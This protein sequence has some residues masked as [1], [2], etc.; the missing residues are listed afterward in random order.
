M[1]EN[2]PEIK[3]YNNLLPTPNY[4]TV[5]D[6]YYERSKL[7][8]SL[9]FEVDARVGDGAEVTSKS[10]VFQLAS[11]LTNELKCDEC[12]RDFIDEQSLKRHKDLVHEVKVAPRF[13][14]AKYLQ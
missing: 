12:K 10:K 9:G 2:L 5:M 4:K 8:R 6:N 7:F 14:L 11:L 1:Q 13:V 3:T